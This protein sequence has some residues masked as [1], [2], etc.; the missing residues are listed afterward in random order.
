MEIACPDGYTFVRFEGGDPAQFRAR[1]ASGQAVTIR[2]ARV[3]APGYRRQVVERLAPMS[4]IRSDHLVQILEVIDDGDDVYVVTEPLAGTW[5]DTELRRGGV[6]PDRIFEVVDRAIAALEVL[7]DAG[8]VHRKLRASAILTAPRGIVIDIPDI[9]YISHAEAANRPVLILPPPPSTI[10]LPEVDRIFPTPA[11]DI[12]AIG[13]LL[14]EAF[15]GHAM[16]A[17]SY[18]DILRRVIGEPAP[19]CPAALSDELRGLIARCLDRDPAAR[20]ALAEVRRDLPPSRFVDLLTSVPA[21]VDPD[22]A[23]LLATL[24]DEPGDEAARLVYADWLEEHGDPDRA[25]FVRT[26]VPTPAGDARWRSIVSRAAIARCPSERP[27][28]PTQWDGFMATERDGVRHCERCTLP[29]FYA[30]TPEEAAAY[31]ADGEIVVVDPALAT[32]T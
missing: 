14:W 32:R 1:E 17:G 2:D 16:H 8:V 19:A 29:V 7:H 21:P 23:A 4:A 15:A 31:T 20:P 18:F 22:E 30:T 26:A 24:R 3:R 28:C 6:S 12:Y 27:S 11:G 13:L 9:G 5:F 10:V 25:A